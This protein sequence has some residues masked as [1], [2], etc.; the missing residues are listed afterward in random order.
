M[1]EIDGSFGEGGG[2]ILRT[3]LSLSCLFEKPF[4]IFNIR[5]GRKK[6]GLMP[7]HLTCVKAM[8]M[9]SDAE[10]TG[11]NIGSLELIFK[12]RLVRGGEFFFDIGTAGSISL[13]LQTMIPSLIFSKDKARIILKGGTH[14]PFSPT[15]DYIS[16]I[17]VPILKR[18]G[19]DIRIKIESYGFYPK[20]GGKVIAE[21]FPAENIKP[22]KIKE[23]GNILKISGYSGVGNLPLSIAERQKS[24]VLKKI[25]SD[26]EGLTCPVEIEVLDVPAFGQGTFTYLHSESENSTAGFT[27][28]GQ[29]GKS[30][31]IVGKETA[32]KFI[33]YYSTNAALDKYLADQI[34]LYLS[35]PKE[36]S[37]FTVSCITQHLITNLWAI[38]IFHNFKYSVNGEIGGH[39][40]VKI[41]VFEK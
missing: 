38:G 33:E 17:F 34:V 39:G 12:P 28:L 6:P 8:Q 15:F 4:R 25:H 30:A 24:A 7:Q 11:D 5:K 27:A 10:V 40:D 18:V 13:V 41:S 1:I 26:M 22:I 2:Q 9:L 37:E 23:R 21:T 29:R 19:I 3:S 32:S 16:N 20:G 14:V 35:M 36:E 31:E